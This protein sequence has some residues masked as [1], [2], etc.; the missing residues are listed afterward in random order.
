MDRLSAPPHAVSGTIRHGGRTVE[1]PL[2][3]T[4]LIV[5]LTC[6]VG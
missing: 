3:G 2:R 1:E 6:P 4:V 5:S